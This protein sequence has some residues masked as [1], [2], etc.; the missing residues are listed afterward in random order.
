MSAS[1]F[2]HLDALIA[3]SAKGSIDREVE[4]FKQMKITHNPPHSLTRKIERLLRKEDTKVQYHTLFKTMKVAGIACLLAVSVTFTACMCIPKVR[5][6]MWEAVVEWYDDYIAVRF[7]PQENLSDS[8]VN[9]IDPPKEIRD[10]NMPTYIPYGYT[11]IA[12]SSKLNFYQEYY[13][14]DGNFIYTFSQGLKDQDHIEFDNS[15]GEIIKLLINEQD[16]VLIIGTDNIMSLIWS[17]SY[18]SYTLQGFF[19]SQ[20]EIIQIANSVLPITK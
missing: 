14:Q 11:V 13:D 9:V 1:N 6:A 18:Y 16:A 10:V 2:D 19:T 7:Q 8:N 15:G 12:Q 17:D 4:H 3:M 5:E 20:D